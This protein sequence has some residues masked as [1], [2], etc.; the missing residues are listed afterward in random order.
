MN[1]IPLLVRL[2]NVPVD[3]KIPRR[4]WQ[5]K[6]NAG[7]IFRDGDLTTQ[8]TCLCQ[9]IGHVKHVIFVFGRLR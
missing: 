2:R 8:P 4:F 5:F 9:S 3:V 6:R 7:H 1:N